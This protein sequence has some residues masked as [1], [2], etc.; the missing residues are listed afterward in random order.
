MLSKA[1]RAITRGVR[2][3][4]VP[5]VPLCNSRRHFDSEEAVGR[6]EDP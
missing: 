4:R 6:E 5:E 2:G 3:L 1:E